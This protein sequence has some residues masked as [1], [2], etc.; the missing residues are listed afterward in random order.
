MKLS[1]IYLFAVVN[2]KLVR[3]ETEV[4]DVDN[5]DTELVEND[6][7]ITTTIETEAGDGT[8]VENTE[9]SDDTG[10]EDVVDN[11][12]QE[13]LEPQNLEGNTSNA[14]DDSTEAG[15]DDGTVNGDTAADGET[16]AE[17]GVDTTG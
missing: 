9:D 15:S 10:A 12:D 2:C 5:T 4:T 13:N 1:L 17:D 3:R 7:P 8:E 11:E 14:G 16:A 6:Q